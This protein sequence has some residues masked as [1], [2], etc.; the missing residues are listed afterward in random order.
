MHKFLCVFMCVFARARAHVCV[1]VCARA[2]A[3]ACVCV[4]RSREQVHARARAC[5]Y[6]FEVNVNKL[7][8]KALSTFLSLCLCLSVC[9]SVCLFPTPLPPSHPPPSPPLSLSSLP[10]LSPAN[11]GT[12]CSTP[13]QHVLCTTRTCMTRQKWLVPP[14][15][16][17]RLQIKL[18]ISAS[19]SILTQGQPVLALPM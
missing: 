11:Q 7:C 12:F 4:L 16:G 8:Q 3:R 10:S 14:H 18:T 2:C 17:K 1:C 5:V 6:D 19:Y 9:L 13:Q 15:S